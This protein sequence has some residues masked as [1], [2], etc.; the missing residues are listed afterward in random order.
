MDWTSFIPGFCA[1]VGITFVICTI[2]DRGIRR[3]IKQLQADVAAFDAAIGSGLAHGL[4][5]S[6]CQRSAGLGDGPGPKEQ[7]ARQAAAVWASKKAVE[8]GVEAYRRGYRP[9]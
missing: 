1:G 9:F 8:S 5:R 7:A 6:D 3:D 4:R 2:W